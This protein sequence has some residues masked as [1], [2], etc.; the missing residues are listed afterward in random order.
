MPPES[1]PPAERSSRRRDALLTAAVELLTSVGVVGVSEAAV[2]ERS[3]VQASAVDYYFGDHATLLI[4]ALRELRVTRHERIGTML[5]HLPPVG[6]ATEDWN[7]AVG[8][9][10]RGMIWV[11]GA[12]AFTD[13]ELC[14][15]ASRVPELAA[16]ARVSLD[17]LQ[18]SIGQLMLSCGVPRGELLGRP[19]TA[20]SHG[21]IV[22]NRARGESEQD[23][24]D[25][26]CH[27]LLALMNGHLAL[28]A[29][30]LPVAERSDPEPAR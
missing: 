9:V 6:S 24:I 28:V 23:L 27:A 11:A 21:L 10:A 26:L 12:G 19:L 14:E 16:E 30:E 5:A 22:Y 25:D 17:Y 20:L 29:G 1:S 4:E 15:Q 8:D 3:G 7:A 2:L 18:E 13:W